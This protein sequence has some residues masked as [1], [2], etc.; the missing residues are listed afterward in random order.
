[1]EI[2]PAKIYY[3]KDGLINNKLKEYNDT[4]PQFIKYIKETL[5]FE[6]IYPLDELKEADKSD[7]VY[8]KTD[9]HWTDWGAYIGYQA[10]LKQLKKT[11][12]IFMKQKKEILIF[13]IVKKSE[14]KQIESI[15]K[16]ILA[17]C[18]IKI[19]IAPLILITNIMMAK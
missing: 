3:A 18:Y 13:L 12:L 2:V 11:F 15:G 9:H 5:N 8:F 6:I 7:Y 14:R 17:I 4:L 10:L 19:K 1:M 16:D